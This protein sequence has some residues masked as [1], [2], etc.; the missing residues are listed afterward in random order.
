VHHQ[1]HIQQG[2]F[3]SQ[4][5]HQAHQHLTPHSPHQHVHAAQHTP[6]VVQPTSVSPQSGS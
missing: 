2:N 4:H 5:A 3:L 6:Q 1:V